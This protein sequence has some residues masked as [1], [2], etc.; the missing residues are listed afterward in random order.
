[1]NIKFTCVIIG[2]TLLVIML[3]AII[4]IHRHFKLK[5]EDHE[6]IENFLKD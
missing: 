2:S 1:L 6:R 5:Y 3:G 4:R